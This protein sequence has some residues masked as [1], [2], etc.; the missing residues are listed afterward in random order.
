MDSSAND[1]W[2][3]QWKMAFKAR[4]FCHL[5]EWSQDSILSFWG[6]QGPWM[7]PGWPLEKHVH[8]SVELL[9]WVAKPLE[10]RVLG[11]SKIGLKWSLIMTIQP[12][13][14][15]IFSGSYTKVRKRLH[16]GLIQTWLGKGNSNTIV[17]FGMWHKWFLKLKLLFLRLA[18]HSSLL[19]YKNKKK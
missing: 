10:E 9:P 8:C 12:L 2:I 15:C 17:V 13:F 11:C 18:I 7:Y 5:F 3:L 16:C 1:F 19:A 4:D 14:W 6:W